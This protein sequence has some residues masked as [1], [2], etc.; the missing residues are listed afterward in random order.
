MEYTGRVGYGK[1][2]QNPWFISKGT[3]QEIGVD[4]HGT[5]NAGHTTSREAWNN[6]AFHYLGLAY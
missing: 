3:F 2:L 4:P 6:E 1:G 5:N